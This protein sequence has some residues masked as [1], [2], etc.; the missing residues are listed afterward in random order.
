L[1]AG[2]ISQREADEM[3]KLAKELYDQIVKW[4]QQNHPDLIPKK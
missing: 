2:R 4:L 1:A 3:K